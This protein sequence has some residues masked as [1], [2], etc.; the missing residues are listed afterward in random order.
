MKT[1]KQL[2]ELLS[3]ATMQSTE[4]RRTWFIDISG[5]VNLLTIRYYRFG[6]SKDDKVYSEIEGKTTSKTDIQALY[7]FVKSR[8]DK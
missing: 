8:L 1:A 7:W 2:F 6:W 4:E 5:H 3:I